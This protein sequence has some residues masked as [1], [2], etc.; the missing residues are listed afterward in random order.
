MNPT[1]NDYQRLI[2]IIFAFFAVSILT[3]GG[4]GIA[5]GMKLQENHQASSK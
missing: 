2:G 4:F 5:I 3:V 1:N